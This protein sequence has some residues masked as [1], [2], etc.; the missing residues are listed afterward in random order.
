M[1]KFDKF[2]QEGKSPNIQPRGSLHKPF[3]NLTQWAKSAKKQSER[4][5]FV[6]IRH[7]KYSAIV[8][9]NTLLQTAF[10]VRYYTCV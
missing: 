9:K 7:S 2:F 4:V 5:R 3:Y 1:F 6:L 8:V 10:S